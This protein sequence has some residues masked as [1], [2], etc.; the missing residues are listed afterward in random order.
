MAE[1]VHKTVDKRKGEKGGARK[2]AKAKPRIEV[3]AAD[4][5][6][7]RGP[8]I[9]EYEDGG[10]PWNRDFMD[11]RPD[12]R[13]PHRK[14][15]AQIAAEE[16][17]ILSWAE[18]KEQDPARWFDSHDLEK[19]AA[20]IWD[21]RLSDIDVGLIGTVAALAAAGCCPT[22]SCTGGPGHWAAMPCVQFW[23]PVRAWARVRHAAVA[24][25]VSLMGRGGMG[26]L[27]WH[28]RDWRP[29]RE[30]G[31]ALSQTPRPRGGARPGGT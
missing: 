25:G 24:A 27:A 4:L 30:F 22:T 1:T 16:G 9:K 17:E 12:I 23:C 2:V 15:L 28:G 10:L 18:E 21:W 19:E 5:G 31:L 8:L 7:P 3:V 29:L 26:I 6:L 14:D 13:G 20:T 11:V